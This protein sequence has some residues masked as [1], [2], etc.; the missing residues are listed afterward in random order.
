MHNRELRPVSLTIVVLGGDL[1]LKLL[2]AGCLA[3]GPIMMMMKKKPR[4]EPR[5]VVGRNSYP[6]YRGNTAGRGS[7]NPV[8]RCPGHGKT[9]FA[10]LES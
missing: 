8:A 7:G 2:F 3:G 10:A 4:P 1:G 5:K 9:R 6:K